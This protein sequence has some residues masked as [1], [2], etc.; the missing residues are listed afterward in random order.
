MLLSELIKKLQAVKKK[1]G[2]I[3]VVY[4]RMSDYGVFDDSDFDVKKAVPVKGAAGK[5]MLSSWPSGFE[6]E[7]EKVLHFAGN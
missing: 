2:D 6:V 5:W 7:T 1:E 3:Q 4:T